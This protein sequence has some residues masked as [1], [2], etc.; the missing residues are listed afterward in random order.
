M[1]LIL[2]AGV[3]IAALAIGYSLVSFLVTLIWFREFAQPGIATL[4][5]GLFFFGGVQLLFLGVLGE[6]TLSIHAQ[7]RQRPLVIE[8]ER[9][10]FEY[11]QRAS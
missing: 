9:I 2:A 11:D 6:Y 7:V 1:R 3:V 5:V 8:A 10:N 4:I